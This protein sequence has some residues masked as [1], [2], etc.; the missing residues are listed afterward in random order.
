M[1]GILYLIGVSHRPNTNPSDAASIIT[2]WSAWLTL[3]SRQMSNIGSMKNV[4]NTSF[5]A[6]L[7]CSPPDAGRIS[8]TTI[9]SSVRMRNA[10]VHRNVASPR[11]YSIQNENNTHDTDS[12]SSVSSGK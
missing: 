8:G 6:N 11:K 5:S 7:R 2:G 1:S 9:R 10:S 4:Q 12:T 3:T